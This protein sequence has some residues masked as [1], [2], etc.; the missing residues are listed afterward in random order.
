MIPGPPATAP[1]RHLLTELAATGRTGAVHVDGLPG[2]TFYL[3]AGRV[4]YAESPA[5]PGIRERLLRSGRLTEADWQAAYREGQARREVGRALVQRGGLEHGELV[6]H[7]LAS[8]CDAGHAVLQT[9]GAHV[10]FA[11]DER[12][13]LGLI[14]QL[15][16]TALSRE[17]ARRQVAT[18]PAPAPRDEPAPDAAP[19]VRRAAPNALPSRHPERP[20]DTR[21][22]NAG[23]RGDDLRHAAPDYATLKRIR[24]ALKSPG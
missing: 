23:P 4:T 24:Q 14:A 9:T 22:G 11:P 2:G 5:C 18:A 10:R 6:C 7:V 1:M 3:V 15:E 20:A 16:L 17:T 21:A 19:A 13:W 8:I 12:H